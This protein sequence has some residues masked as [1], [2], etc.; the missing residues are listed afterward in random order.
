MAYQR[1][2]ALFTLLT[3]IL[4]TYFYSPR[5]TS[6]SPYRYVC[7][8][9]AYTH[10]PYLPPIDDA[11]SSLLAA[12]AEYASSKGLQKTTY[13]HVSR[14]NGQ[15]GTY[16]TDCSCF[17]S[18]L[19]YTTGLTAH[20]QDV[21]KERNDTAVDPPMPR[22][23]D[24]A[25]FIY[26]LNSTHPRW[27][28]IHRVSDLIPGDLITWSIPSRTTNTGHMMVVLADPITIPVSTNETWVHVAD[29]SSIT[30]EWDSACHDGVC[31]R[32]GVGQGFVMLLER[33]GRIVGFKFR[34]GARERWWEVGVG[35]LL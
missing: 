1:P 17:V 18:Y 24:Y 19:L 27:K 15:R 8:L 23:Q 35:R 32:W 25:N 9:G 13:T 34:S 4:V 21:P 10:L 16:H 20:L 2:L 5:T 3:F 6:S 22:A 33:A 29:A 12:A 14:I 7:D 30:H 28:R 31:K 26:G 11:P